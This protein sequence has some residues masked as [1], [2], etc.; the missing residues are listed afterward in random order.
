MLVPLL[1]GRRAA[2]TALGVVVMVA[3]AVAVLRTLGRV[4]PDVA[5]ALPSAARALELALALFSTFA[6]PIAAILVTSAAIDYWLEQK[7]WLARLRMS[8]QEI[9]EERRE[10]EGDPLMRRARRRAHEELARRPPH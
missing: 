7:F 6:L 5:H 8:P 1:D 4:A 9:K 10:Q 3:I 2:R